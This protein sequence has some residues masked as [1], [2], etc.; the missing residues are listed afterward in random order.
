MYSVMPRSITAVDP[1]RSRWPKEQVDFQNLDRSP[2]LEDLTLIPL[3]K[4]FIPLAVL[5]PPQPRDIASDNL[6]KP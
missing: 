5:L 3:P 2:I 1:R 4:S 6:L